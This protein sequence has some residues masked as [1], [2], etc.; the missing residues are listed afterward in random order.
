MNSTHLVLQGKGGVGK[1]LIANLLAKYSQLNGDK[2]GEDRE[3]KRP[4]SNTK[5]KS[6]KSMK[7][8]K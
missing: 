2:V 5:K 8:K 6:S 7:F 4:Q 1:S 3:K